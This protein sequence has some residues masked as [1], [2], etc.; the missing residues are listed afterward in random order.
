MTETIRRVRL[1]LVAAALV[2]ALSGLVV[3]LVRLHLWS[4]PEQREIAVKGR[5][6]HEPISS[7]RGM[8]ADNSTP[9]TI[10][11]IDWPCVDVCADPKLIQLTNRVPVVARELARV[12]PGVDV[13][14]LEKRLSVPDRHFERVARQVT[15]NVAAQ[16]ALLKLPGVF[17]TPSVVRRYPQGATLCHVLG[18]VNDEGVGSAGL[19]QSLEKFLRGTPGEIVGYRDGRRREMADRRITETAAK[20]GANIALTIDQQVQF[21]VERAL[22]TVMERHHPESAW[23][24]VERI[25]TG[26]IMAMACRPNYDPNSFRASTDLQRMNRAIGYTYEPG[27]TFKVATIMAALDQGIVT[28]ENK[29]DCE[30][31]RWW[32]QGKVLRDTHPYGVLSVAD[33]L[34]KS[35]NIG[36][37][38]ITVALGGPQLETYL[39]AFQFGHRLGIDLPGEEGGIVAPYAKWSAISSSRIAMGQ[40]VAVTALQMLGLL[41]CIANDGAYMKPYVVRSV[42]ADNGAILRENRPTVLAHPIKTSTAA[43]MREMLVRVTETGGTGVRAAVPGFRVAGKTGTGQKVIGGRYSETDYMAS[44]VG[45]LPADKP[46]IGLIVVV[47]NPQPLHTGGMVAGPAF[48][49]IAEQAM[50]YLDVPRSPLALPVDMAG[51]P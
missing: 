11:A 17:T 33:V 26:E 7:H 22:D 8:I 9:S 38:K 28:A 37:A 15:T 20:P 32:Y 43:A 40:G 10:M 44:F 34:Q 49:E 48:S 25:K 51:K 12:L 24:I 27:S 1:T 46:E 42:M 31:G 4:E 6:L 36:A 41:C 13:A 19:E 30:N 23:A 3:Q 35:S 45:F 47:D 21:M 50:R 16:L 2:L 5:I 14:A 39:K 29:F 18:Y